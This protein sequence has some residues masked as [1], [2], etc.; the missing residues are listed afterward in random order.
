MRRRQGVGR[1]S[2]AKMSESSW[3]QCVS[4][5]QQRPQCHYKVTE[6][7]HDKQN[8]EP[9]VG[10][11][12]TFIVMEVFGHFDAVFLQQSFFGLNVFGCALVYFC[13]FIR[14]DCGLDD[15][16][17]FRLDNGVADAI[18]DVVRA[19]LGRKQGFESRPLPLEGMPQTSVYA[20][21]FLFEGVDFL[22]QGA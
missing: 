2:I 14:A 1:W 3:K 18:H 7:L 10:Q 15:G 5:F 16:M 11:P 8:R 9:S 22:K 17:P 21:Q 6:K 13:Q 19:V 20:V 12:D 4:S